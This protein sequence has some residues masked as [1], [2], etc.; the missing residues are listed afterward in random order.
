MKINKLLEFL[1][2]SLQFRQTQRAIYAV[3]ENRMEN[4][5][6]H[7]YQLTILTWYVI[8]SEKLKLDSN[9]AIKY[10][11]I[12]DLEE[13]ITG[14][15]PIF[16]KKS[17]SGKENQEKLAYEIISKMFPDW[18][19]YKKL[20]TNYKN[21]KDE[22]SKLVNGLDKIL[23][24]LNIYIDGGRIWKTEDTTLKTLSENKKEKVA[25]HPF[26]KRMWIDIEKKL[27]AKELE[28]FGKLSK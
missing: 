17:R 2:F 10:A 16:D 4:D 25:I 14:D 24:V 9:L 26:S 19:E 6:E 15:K 7:S 12:H 11:L 22:E 18:K 27:Q 3:G 13:A 1:K 20:S 5:V 28:L 21:K 23:P 8:E